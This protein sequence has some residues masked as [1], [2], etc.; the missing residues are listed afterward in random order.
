MKTKYLKS[1]AKINLFLKVG[2]KIKKNNLH[3]VQSLVFLINLFDVIKIKKINRYK[4][5][6]KFLGRFNKNVLKSNNTIDKSMRMLREK[7]FVKKNSK[8]SIEVTKNIPVF[9]GFG[10]GSSNAATIVKY[11]SKNRKLSFTD[12]SYFSE[13]IG[14]DFKIF[15]KSRQIYQ[16]NLIKII[17]LA[18]KHKFY[19]ILIYPYLKCSTKHIYSNLKFFER[20]KKESFF[21]NV[22]KSKILEK[23]KYNKNSLEKVAISKFPVIKDILLELR[24]TKGC[25]FSRLTGSGSACYGA[26]L[27]KKSADLGLK[28]IKKKFPK[29]W[30]VSS[31]TI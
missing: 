14:S 29:F 3:D 31:K 28:K 27:T 22:S 11:F 4:D 5:Q 7:G 9:S 10:G 15:L 23:I 26:F 8:Y 24:F 1:Y 16:E 20:I 17:D 2:K 12:I 25:Q 13:K 19:F 30:R 18:K 6:I 21:S